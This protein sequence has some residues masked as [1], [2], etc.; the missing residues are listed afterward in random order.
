MSPQRFRAFFLPLRVS[1]PQVFFP[2]TSLF[3]KFFFLCAF[4]F[5]KFF[6]GRLALASLQLEQRLLLPTLPSP[7]LTLLWLSWRPNS[8]STF[9]LVH[10]TKDCIFVATLCISLTRFLS[11]IPR[12]IA[13]NFVCLSVSYHFIMFRR[14]TCWA[15][16]CLCNVTFPFILVNFC[17]KVFIVCLHFAGIVILILICI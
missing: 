2:C 6:L 10:E 7:P 11:C 5:L 16:P 14:L 4:L 1:L 9:G 12:R 13:C 8:I 15:W 17:V 3:L